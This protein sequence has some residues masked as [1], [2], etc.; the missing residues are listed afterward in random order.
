[1]KITV[2]IVCYKRFENLEKIIQAWLDQKEVN[3][4][5]VWDNSGS[6]KTKLTALVV[7][8]SQNLGPTAKFSLSQLADNNVILYADD[9]V[10][11]KD[12]FVKD[13]L[14][15]LKPNRIVGVQG[16]IFD[17]TNYYN[18]SMHYGNKAEKPII[19]DYLCGFIMM[20]NKGHSLGVNLKAC[21]SWFLIEDWWW[22]HTVKA[23]LVVVPTN[24]YELLAERNIDPLHQR[25]EIKKIREEYYKKWVLNGKEDL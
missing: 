3:Q 13:L 8:S 6:F 23:E 4:V 17:G 11:P 25:P 24:K 9:D 14:P 21:P 16:R 19:V 5:I 20:A 12:G 22:E 1:M 2:I 18:S 7:S 10:M 15:H